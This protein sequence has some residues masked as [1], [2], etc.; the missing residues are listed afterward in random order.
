MKRSFSPPFIEYIANECAQYGPFLSKIIWL[1]HVAQW[2]TVVTRR[3]EF[4]HK[5]AIFL[6]NS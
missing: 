1:K 3:T 6:N 4:N 2:S 5:I